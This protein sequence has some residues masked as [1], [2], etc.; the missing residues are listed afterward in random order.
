MQLSGLCLCLGHIDPPIVAPFTTT[1]RR[2]SNACYRWNAESGGL[3]VFKGRPSTR[4]A[5]KKRFGLPWLAFDVTCPFLSD[6]LWSKEAIE[7]GK[8]DGGQPFHDQ[9]AQ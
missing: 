5:S 8:D 1:V 4:G 6:Y 7:E 9:C 3:G 2:R